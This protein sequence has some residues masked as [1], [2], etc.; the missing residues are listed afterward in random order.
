M[1][2]IVQKLGSYKKLRTEELMLKIL[3]KKKLGEAKDYMKELDKFLPPSPI[4]KDR[5]KKEKE[6]EPLDQNAPDPSSKSLPAHPQKPK[7]KTLEDEI[8]EIRQK[9]ARLS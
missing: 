3:L 6:V 5:I 2:S 8:E 7:P 1:L 4:K 9:I